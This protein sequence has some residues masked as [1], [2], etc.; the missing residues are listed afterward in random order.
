MGG[1]DEGWGPT[2]SH[3]HEEGVQTLKQ[4]SV[5]TDE[6]PENANIEGAGIHTF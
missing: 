5:D 2:R 4:S 6:N 1:R 3:V